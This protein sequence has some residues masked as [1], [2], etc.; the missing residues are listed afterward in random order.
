MEEP[1]DLEVPGTGTLSS[2]F[3]VGKVD[4]MSVG[5][6][7]SIVL[8]NSG[9]DKILGQGMFG[10][11]GPSEFLKSFQP[12]YY[13]KR[14][15]T[16][17]GFLSKDFRDPSWKLWGIPRDSTET[18]LEVVRSVAERPALWEAEQTIK[19]TCRA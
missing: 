5:Q 4:D 18:K 12:V 15:S 11:G 19:Q 13:I 6:G 1:L 17:T 2:L 3:T 8:I 10:F 7:A 14:V 9:L 16:G